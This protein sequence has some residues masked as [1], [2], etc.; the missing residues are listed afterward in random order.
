MA[1]SRSNTMRQLSGNL[2]TLLR[3]K[4]LISNTIKTMAFSVGILLVNVLTGVITARLLGPEGRGVQMAIILWPQFFSFT[5]TLGLHAALLYHIKKSPEEEGALYYSSLLMTIGTSLAGIVIGLLV[6]PWRL[7]DHS[8]EIILA[9][10]W[11]MLVVPF[12]HLYFLNNALVRAKED[13]RRFNQMRYQLP[14]ITLALLLGLAVTGYITPVTAGIA[15]LLPYVPVAL[16][17]LIRGMRSYRPKLRAIRKVNGRML[18]YGLGSY[19]VDLLGNLILYIDQIVLIGL[20][21]PAS[22]GLYVVAVSLSRMVNVFSASIIM[23]LFPQASG[24]GEKDAALLSLR[25]YKVSTT[26]A[27]FGSLCIMAL[28][29]LVIHLLYGE[30]FLNSIPVFRLLLLEVVIG[31][32][33]MVLGQA[34][35]AAGKPSIVSISQGIGI[36]LIVPLL[37]VLV[38]RFGVVGAGYGLLIAAIVR[39]VYMLLAFEYKFQFGFRALLL[40]KA[41]IHWFIGLLHERKHRKTNEGRAVE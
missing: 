17:S 26:I 27:L 2:L 36:V 7:S 5:T 14:L 37:Y 30:I 16:G 29:P 35:M 23:V 32:A 22:L 1:N 41:D 28:A 31:G 8:G 13:F 19:G 24:L 21:S 34:F 25:V 39:L 20:L 6:I 38:P 33:A 3:G 12:M 10:L 9:S 15:Y 4:G 40:S 18:K 11:F